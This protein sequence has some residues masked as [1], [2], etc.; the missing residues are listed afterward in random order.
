MLA[1]YVLL[2]LEEL[3]TCCDDPVRCAKA[4]KSKLQFDLHA[5]PEVSLHVMTLAPLQ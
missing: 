3:I 2:L 4:S 5:S 1:I